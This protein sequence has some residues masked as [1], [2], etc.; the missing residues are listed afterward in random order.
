MV[1]YGR[2]VKIPEK[3][4]ELFELPQCDFLEEELFGIT[5]W[6]PKNPWSGKGWYNK[7]ECKSKAIKKRK[8]WFGELEYRNGKLIFKIE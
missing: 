4:S 8:E 3:E 5:G 2:Y 6:G 7:I 1:R